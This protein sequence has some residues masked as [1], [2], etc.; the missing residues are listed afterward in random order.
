MDNTNFQESNF[1]LIVLDQSFCIIPFLS[2]I[3]YLLSSSNQKYCRF[4][5]HSFTIIFLKFGYSHCILAY[6]KTL[7]IYIRSTSF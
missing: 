5:I 1:S 2:L 7:S 4:H 6:P 3:S